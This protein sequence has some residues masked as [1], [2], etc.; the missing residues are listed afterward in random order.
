MNIEKLLLISSFN[1]GQI[2]GINM[3]NELTMLSAAEFILN[4][5]N[6]RKLNQNS[7]HFNKIY[8]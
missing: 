7:N 4:L 5:S 6:F 2:M 1:R 3:D 8:V